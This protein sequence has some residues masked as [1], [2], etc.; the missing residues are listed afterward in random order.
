M[1]DVAVEP[2]IG[3]W[4]VHGLTVAADEDLLG[5]DAP[6]TVIGTGETRPAGCAGCVG[7]RLVMT[8]H[9][10]EAGVAVTPGGDPRSSGGGRWE[11]AGRAVGEVRA[12]DGDDPARRTGAWWR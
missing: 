5:Q 8:P 3:W 12:G 6:T 1:S 9:T 7:T 2:G 10:Q 11:A 4:T